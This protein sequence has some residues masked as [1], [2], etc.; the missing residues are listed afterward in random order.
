MTSS[1]N[2][3]ALAAALSAT[4]LNGAPAAAQGTAHASCTVA[5]APATIS[6]IVS[7]ETPS[8]LSLIGVTGNA[9]VQVSLSDTGALENATIAKSSGNASL[10]AAAITAAREQKYSPE[11]SDC[12][13]V[14]G[15]YLIHV[16]FSNS[17]NS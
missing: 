16:D 2:V 11:R 7:A 13:P 1:R 9:D 4:L 17:L 10:D 3:L 14:G 8:F 5:S 12:Q 15:T 6:D